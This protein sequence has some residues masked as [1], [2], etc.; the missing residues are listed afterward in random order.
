MNRQI[1]IP[2]TWIPLSDIINF[3][4]AVGKMGRT[5]DGQRG[6]ILRFRGRNVVLGTDRGREVTVPVVE[7]EVLA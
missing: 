2:T 6:T 3:L 5:H 7:C 1:G 4:D